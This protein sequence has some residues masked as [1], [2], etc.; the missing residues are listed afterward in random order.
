[1][2][3]TEKV[4]EAVAEALVEVYGHVPNPSV[5]TAQQIADAALEGAGVR[6]EFIVCGA[7][8]YPDP[9]VP[10][11]NSLVDAQRFAAE[12]AGPR[13]SGKTYT[14]VIKRR[15]VSAWEDAR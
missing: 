15:L 2:R 9:H 6:E 10:H 11:P 8:G 13:P 5:L 3:T 7:A 4:R 12:H 14:P 1:M